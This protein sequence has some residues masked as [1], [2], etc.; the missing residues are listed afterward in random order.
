MF[1]RYNTVR[2]VEQAIRGGLPPPFGPNTPVVAACSIFFYAH[3]TAGR[4][5]PQSTVAALKPYA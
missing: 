3:K 1:A 5:G 4:R 2:L